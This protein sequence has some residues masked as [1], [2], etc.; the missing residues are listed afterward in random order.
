MIIGR[1][2]RRKGGS[3]AIQAL[4]HAAEDLSLTFLGD[5]PDRRRLERLARRLSMEARVHFR[6]EVPRAQLPGYYAT[7]AAGIFVGLREEGGL[8][9]AEAMLAGLPVIVLANGGPQTIASLTADPTR[10]A[11]IDSGSVEE[12]ARQIGTA[13]TRFSRMPPTRKPLL[14]TASGDFFIREV[15]ASVLPSRSSPLP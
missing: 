1:L 15:L 12:A 9:L 7:A 2:E 13:M 5:G 8:A 10:V 14:D 3:L 6:G 11:V 4:T